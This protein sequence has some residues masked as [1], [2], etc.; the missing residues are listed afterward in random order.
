MR[1]DCGAHG[2]CRKGSGWGLLCCYVLYEYGPHFY[3]PSV[4]LLLAFISY[5]ATKLSRQLRALKAQNHTGCFALVSQVGGEKSTM[6]RT[7]AP[8]LTTPNMVKS[9]L[10]VFSLLPN[11]IPP[12][13]THI[14]LHTTYMRDIRT[15]IPFNMPYSYMSSSA[16]PASAERG[17][18]GF[19]TWAN[20]T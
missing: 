8:F 10:H 5:I 20:S 15:Y 2:V 1:A 12:Y 16:A 18:G 17:R 9:I 4:F 13:F 19:S 7:L 3:S 6:S 14:M 11:H